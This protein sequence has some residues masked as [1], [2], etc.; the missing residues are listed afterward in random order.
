MLRSC[1]ARQEPYIP[2]PY[3]SLRELS[4]SGF[5]DPDIWCPPAFV[6]NSGIER[7]NGERGFAL[8][9]PMTAAMAVVMAAFV[10]AIH[11]LIASLEGK[12][13]N[14][15]DKPRQPP[16]MTVLDVELPRLS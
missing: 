16:A 13:F 9:D 2:G 1:F 4:L 12:P 3:R 11:V 7:S 14:F 10:P 8:S 15:R 5:V 6:G